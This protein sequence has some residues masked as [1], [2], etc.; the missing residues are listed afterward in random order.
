MRKIKIK[1]GDKY[2]IKLREKLNA[3]ELR[4]CKGDADLK[5]KDEEIK[6]LKQEIYQIEKENNQITPFMQ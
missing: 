3:V 5:Q 2:L 4:P 6:A 1:D